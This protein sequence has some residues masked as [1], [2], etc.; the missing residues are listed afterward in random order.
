MYTVQQ[1]KFLDKSLQDFKKRKV[2]RVVPLQL[3]MRST[4]MSHTCLTWL[5]LP[6]QWIESDTGHSIIDAYG[7]STS[8]HLTPLPVHVG[9]AGPDTVMRHAPLGVID[10]VGEGLRA[11]KLYLLHIVHMVRDAAVRRQRDTHPPPALDV[12]LLPHSVHN[13][14]RVNIC[15]RKQ[16]GTHEPWK[17]RS[18]QHF[19]KTTNTIYIN[20]FTKFTLKKL[21]MVQVYFINLV[22]FY[23]T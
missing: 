4:S 16:R 9:D 17:K 11:G 12:Q 2:Q 15:E 3:C 1:N 7:S 8:A 6:D 5:Y 21:F 20:T 22:L 13:K 10:S 14:A 18:A 19:R 23:F